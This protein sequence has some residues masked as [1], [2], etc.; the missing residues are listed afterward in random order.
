[1]L[2]VVIRATPLAI[3][4]AIGLTALSGCGSEASTVSPAAAAGPDA[5]APDRSAIEAP[6]GVATVAPEDAAAVIAG[7]PD[8][9][10]VLDI[11]TPEEF[12]EGHLE[13]AILIDFYEAD[14]VQRLSELDRDTPYVLYCRS[15]NRSG[16]TVPVM[17]QLGFRSVSDVGGGILAWQAAGLPVT[18]G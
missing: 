7:A 4:L 11:R 3:A 14:F 8:D 17:E 1:M 13:G 5:T 10:V 15:G 16:Q 18:N 9:V 2:T 12:D 6:V